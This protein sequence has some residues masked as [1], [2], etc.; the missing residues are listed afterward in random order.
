MRRERTPNASGKVKSWEAWFSFVLLVTLNVMNYVDRF[1]PSAL[2]EL[3]KADLN[4]SDVQT[5][6]VFTC[7]VVSNIVFSP[8]F[9]LLGDLGV[10]PRR[11]L[12]IFGVV[13]WS[14]ATC[15]TSLSRS[16]WTLLIPRLFVGIGESAYGTLGV[17]L[18]CD[19]FPK[20]SHN[21][22]LGIY[23]CAIPVGSALG[24]A[25]SRGGKKTA[26]TS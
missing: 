21:L 22:L 5:G 26:D 24:S 11:V 6:I 4:L 15:L 3:I 14:V 9:G 17:P 20:R 16:F 18:I 1:T 13:A 25:V 7:F 10:L 8:V 12:I 23:M 2:K 19:L